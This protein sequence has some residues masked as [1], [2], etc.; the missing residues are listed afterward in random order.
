M[1]DEFQ[2][3]YDP[4]HFVRYVSMCLISS[5]DS[6]LYKFEKLFELKL[7]NQEKHAYN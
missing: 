2:N 4:F 1:N 3:Y 5:S 6:K 7:N